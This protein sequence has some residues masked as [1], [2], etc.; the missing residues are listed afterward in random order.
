MSAKKST[1][2]S[3]DAS[4][5]KEAADMPEVNEDGTAEAPVTEEVLKD[6]S[7]EEG[8]PVPEGAKEEA[9]DAPAEEDVVLQE[10]TKAPIVEQVTEEPL[11]PKHPTLRPNQGKQ[12]KKAVEVEEDPRL[13]EPVRVHVLKT[14]PSAPS[15]G[16]WDWRKHLGNTCTAGTT[17]VV[18]RFVAD[19]LRSLNVVTIVE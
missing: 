8:L 6:E 3:I 13:F 1:K 5:L 14:K 17:H 10:G 11:V 2:K 7:L 19:H 15:V 4:T 12:P 18:P 9:T 16:S